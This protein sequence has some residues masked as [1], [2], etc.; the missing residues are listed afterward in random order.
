MTRSSVTVSVYIHI[1]LHSLYHKQ[2]HRHNENAQV[3][4]GGETVEGES[5]KSFQGHM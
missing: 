4:P 3:V 1:T 5:V 2:P